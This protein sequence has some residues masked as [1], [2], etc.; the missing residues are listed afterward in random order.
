MGSDVGSVCRS[1]EESRSA[2]TADSVRQ[3]SVR[4]RTFDGRVTLDHRGKR[5]RD[6]CAQRKEDRDRN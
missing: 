6:G 5:E 4:E 2:V 1:T 3:K